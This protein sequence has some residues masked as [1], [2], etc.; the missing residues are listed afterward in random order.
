MPI[1]IATRARERSTVAIDLMFTDADGA[2]MTPLTLTWSLRDGDGAIVNSRQDVSVAS[3]AS[4]VTIVLSGDDLAITAGERGHLRVLTV[5]GTF[6][7]D[8]GTGLPFTEEARFSIDNL[9]GIT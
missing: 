6:T 7:S 5:R 2:A 9:V 3:P 4:T 8:L 1:T